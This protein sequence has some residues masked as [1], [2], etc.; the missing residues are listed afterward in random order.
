MPLTG[1]D[2]NFVHEVT[3]RQKVYLHSILSLYSGE[4]AM[5]NWWWSPWVELIE[6]LQPNIRFSMKCLS[7]QNPLIK[8]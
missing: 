2:L 5:L 8:A 4:E 3:G 1:T 6:S 7:R